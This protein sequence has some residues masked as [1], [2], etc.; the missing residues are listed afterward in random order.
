M[1]RSVHF[2][3]LIQLSSLGCWIDILE[4]R[5][6]ALE[7]IPDSQSHV[8]LTSSFLS[9]GPGEGYDVVASLPIG[10]QRLV[11]KGLLLKGTR[12][13]LARFSYAWRYGVDA[14]PKSDHQFADYAAANPH[15]AIEEPSLE[16]CLLLALF[17][18]S[19]MRW[20]AAPNF[21]AGILCH[22]ILRTKLAQAL[23]LVPITDDTIECLIWLW[24]VLIYAFCLEG[25]VLPDGLSYLGEFKFHFPEYHSWT[26]V[27]SD[28]LPKFFWRDEDSVAIRKAWN[29]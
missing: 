12:R 27:E 24:M 6:N 22:T 5:P 18:Y 13:L 1:G 11:A 21:V 2:A 25:S 15:L 8:I 23:P 17:C 14:I 26:M 16:K 3:T 9:F 28:I 7:I 4:G 20:S 10:F 19:R 29:C